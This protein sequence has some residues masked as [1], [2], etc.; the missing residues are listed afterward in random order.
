MHAIAVALL[1][2]L[3]TAAEGGQPAPT[4]AD[5]RPTE[6]WGWIEEPGF[7]T[8]FP[9]G[10]KS[11]DQKVDTQLGPMTIKTLV[12]EDQERAVVFSY[13]DMPQALVDQVLPF[14]LL[15][16]GR[17]GALANVGAKADRELQGVVESGTAGRVWPS[18][19]ISATGPKGVRLELFLCLAGARLYQVVEVRPGGSVEAWRIDR[20]VSS[21]KLREPR[22]ASAEAEKGP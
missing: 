6:A 13:T 16:G 12:F 9:V 7:R 22:R 21:L 14:K 5:S 8:E 15:D 10:A 17:D 19:R 11:Q 1:L 3:L 20:V 2:G 4:A 18:R